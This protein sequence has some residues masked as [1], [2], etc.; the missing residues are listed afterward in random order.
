MNDMGGH[1]AVGDDL[2]LPKGLCKT[3]KGVPNIFDLGCT[4]AV[5]P[6]KEDFMGT[7]RMVNKAPNGLEVLKQRLQGKGLSYNNSVM[8]SG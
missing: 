1:T 2:F 5:T 3:D 6:H 4:H 7:V 8:I